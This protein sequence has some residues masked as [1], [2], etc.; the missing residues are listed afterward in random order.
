MYDI[1]MQTEWVEREEP[2]VIS[3]GREGTFLKHT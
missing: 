2:V 3:P 1:F